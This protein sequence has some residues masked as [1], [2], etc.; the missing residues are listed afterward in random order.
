[1]TLLMGLGG[2]ENITKSASN[3]FWAGSTER[4]ELV[5]AIWHDIGPDNSS[6]SQS[7]N[8]CLTNER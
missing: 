1:M 8:V 7:R 5:K 6:A 2:L 4:L 3:R